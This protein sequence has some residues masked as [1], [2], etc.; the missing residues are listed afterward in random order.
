MG[1]PNSVF[2]KPLGTGSGSVAA[3]VASAWNNAGRGELGKLV[4]SAGQSAY[5]VVTTP[6]AVISGRENLSQGLQREGG[7]ILNFSS[8]GLSSYLGQTSLVQHSGGFIGDYFKG[9]NQLQ[10]TGSLKNEYAIGMLETGA[11]AAAIAAGAAYG[12]SLFSSSPASGGAVDVTSAQDAAIGAGS[13]VGVTSSNIGLGAVANSPAWYS[14]IIGGAESGLGTGVTTAATLEA[15][16]L[17]TGSSGAPGASSSTDPYS[18]APSDPT[19][20]FLPAVNSM[21]SAPQDV[22]YGYGVNDQAGATSPGSASGSTPIWIPLAGLAL[23]YFS[24]ARHKHA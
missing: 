22:P 4:S 12:P 13:D 10:T 17:L 14:G 19:G 9:V 21:P 3:N 1:G 11:T 16:K 18:G 5:D 6:F 15:A 20:G 24:Y 7:S 8:G 2:R 23:A